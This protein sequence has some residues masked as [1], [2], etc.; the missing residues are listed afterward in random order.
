MFSKK[1]SKTCIFIIITFIF[2]VCVMMYS[3]FTY[4]RANINSDTATAS[5]L[6][7]SILFHKS[8]F[9]QEWNYANG[10]IW[11]LYPQLPMLIFTNIIKDQSLARCFGSLTI[12]FIASFTLF[13]QSKKLFKNNTWLITIP[14]LF[15]LLSNMEIRDYLLY[16]A[17]YS[18]QI[19]WMGLGTSFI[20]IIYTSINKQVHLSIYTIFILYSF[21]FFILSISGIR[22]IAEQSVPLSLTILVLHFYLKSPNHSN[23]KSLIATEL[24]IIIPAVL[25]SIAYSYICHKNGIHSSGNS[26][27]S[28]AFSAKDIVSN[29][30]TP[31]LNMLDCFGLENTTSI[32]ALD[33]YKNIISIMFFLFS[34]I[35]SPI[36]F[37]KLP[38]LK[39][40]VSLLFFYIFTIIHNIEMIILVVFFN[41]TETRYILSSVFLCI[42]LFIQYI[43]SIFKNYTSISINMRYL[44]I[45]FYA[46]IILVEAICLFKTSKNWNSTLQYKQELNQYISKYNL[47]KGYATYWNA[48]SNEVYSNFDI[49][50]GSIIIGEH[51]LYPY[52]WLC[53]EIVYIPN[54]N[55]SSFLLLTEDELDSFNPQKFNLDPIQITQKEN[56][57]IFMFDHDIAMDFANY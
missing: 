18:T 35:V 39:D 10:E 46:S 33:Y 3:I 53:D 43:Y 8:P 57:Y 41:K 36:A 52:H 1:I 9:P 19:I 47:T 51:S 27:L 42:I 15:L 49:T 6:A 50:Y 11:T 34:C 24:L 23:N 4:G 12:I 40:N 55:I 28:L 54:N 30:F 22:I 7:Q 37:I 5:I 56:Y 2:S 45:C 32:F 17:C 48:Y 25:G 44:L 38:K 21:L 14:T 20:Y 29:L 13:Y 31:F 16:Q 26:T